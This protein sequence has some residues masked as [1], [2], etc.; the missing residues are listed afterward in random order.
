MAIPESTRNKS[1]YCYIDEIC[2]WP[3]WKK[4]IPQANSKMTTVLIAVAKFELT[5]LMPTLA[6]IAVRAA[7]NAE[8]K[9]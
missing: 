2:L 7:K 5:S 9:A 4:T 3:P 6:K 8:S 1:E